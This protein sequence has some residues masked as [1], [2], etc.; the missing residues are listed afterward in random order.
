MKPNRAAKLNPLSDG[1]QIRTVRDNIVMRA[2]KGP[3]GG[4][5]RRDAPLR[6]GDQ[7][8]LISKPGKYSEYKEG[9]VAWSEDLFRV[10]RLVRNGGV[11][12]YKLQ[13]KNEPVLRH[14][15]LKIAGARAPS[16]RGARR[17]VEARARALPLFE[18]VGNKLFMREPG[19]QNPEPARR[20]LFIQDLFR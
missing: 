15:L 1:E 8:R 13:G 5:P 19:M 6:V 10:E 14:E 7:V 20:P 16:M 12:R 17:Q 18:A 4:Q 9:F 2:R 3:L 11:V